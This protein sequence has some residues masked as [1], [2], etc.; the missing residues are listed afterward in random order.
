MLCCVNLGKE[1]NHLDEHAGWSYW[2]RMAITETGL[3]MVV[4]LPIS[5]WERFAYI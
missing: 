5:G 1:I 4:A 3:A 2:R